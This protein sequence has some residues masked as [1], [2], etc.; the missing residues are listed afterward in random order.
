MTKETH[1]T[2][3]ASARFTG[4]SPIHL[5]CS[6]IIVL[7]TIFSSLNTS[8]QL[9]FTNLSS[10]SF[11]L[12]PTFN[13]LPKLLTNLPIPKSSSSLHL[14]YAY[15]SSPPHNQLGNLLSLIPNI[16]SP[17]FPEQFHR[18]APFITSKL[19]LLSCCKY[20]HNLLPVVRLEFVR[21]VDDVETD[22]SGG[23]DVG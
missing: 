20:R 7:A 23:V 12:H 6:C 18:I 14:Q 9:P 19:P 2:L 21:R 3:V 4:C 17:R 16:E 13:T 22:G 1:R 11:P 10:P 8:L 5:S 15:S